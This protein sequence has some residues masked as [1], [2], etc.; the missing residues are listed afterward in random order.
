MTVFLPFISL[1]RIDSRRQ[2]SMIYFF[3]HYELPVI[4]QQAQV[5]QILRLRTRQ[6]HQQQ[7]GSAPG[8][9]SNAPT[10]RPPA[11]SASP[12][13]PANE[14]A[15]GPN[16]AANQFNNNNNNVTNNNTINAATAG[17]GVVLFLS[18]FFAQHM[19]L[20][21]ILGVIDAVRNV[22]MNDV[23]GA[24]IFFN[25]NNDNN[26]NNNN[27]G[28]AARIR[29]NFTNN[30]LRRINL[31]SIEINPNESAANRHDDSEDEHGDE[32][33][34]VLNADE[35]GRNGNF[36]A[37]E[38]EA[39]I[40]F[41]QRDECNETPTR[42]RFGIDVD[43]GKQMKE[44]PDQELPIIGASNESATEKADIGGLS[45]RRR[46]DEASAAADARNQ[47]RNAK[48]LGAFEDGGG[49]GSRNP[50]RAANGDNGERIDPASGERSIG[51][52]ECDVA[53]SCRIS[54]CC[55]GGNGNESTGN[56]LQKTVNAVDEAM[57][58]T[59]STKSEN[60]LA[61][62]D[63]SNCSLINFNEIQIVSPAELA[64]TATTP[65]PPDAKQQETGNAAS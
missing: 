18:N 8:G 57:P 6:R 51:D 54:Q 4:I 14:P 13:S 63:H 42:E 29:I 2:H 53:H 47:E 37:A 5:Q 32:S 59:L 36:G 15:N 30:N 41:P 60:N 23:F 45:D 12:A 62:N 3:H 55:D 19:L 1:S 46:C 40:H 43:A 39:E 48:V 58:T 65:A 61:K 17:R 27:R 22:I 34:N 64:I 26:L 7:A 21:R 24:T 11:D 35:H 38:V 31:S 16:P 44:E 56:R 9:G 25:N 50:C 49:D 10:H 52:I 28:G 33:R 20:N